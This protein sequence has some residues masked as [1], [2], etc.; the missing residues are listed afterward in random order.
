MARR[1][2]RLVVVFALAGVVINAG[3]AQLAGH[4]HW[5]ERIGRAGWYRI[6]DGGA[7]VRMYPAFG[8]CSASWMSVG[9]SEMA[10][11]EASAPG[12][13][14]EPWDPARPVPPYGSERDLPAWLRACIREHRAWDKATRRA[15]ASGE[16]SLP[17]GYG[18]G[19]GFPLASFAVWYAPGPSSSYGPLAADCH[20][21]LMTEPWYVGSDAVNAWAWRPVW[22]GLF[23][24]SLVWGVAARAAAVRLGRARSLFRVRASY[25]ARRGRCT[26]C[27]YDRAGLPEGCRCPECGTPV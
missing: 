13:A 1:H 17:S 15:E 2:A 3:V 23:I 18:V 4:T 25:R 19:L 9:G 7:R 11:G 27:G 21:G 22:P 16:P 5:G 6:G 20:G 12:A 26:A 8:R 10:E 24:N 14:S